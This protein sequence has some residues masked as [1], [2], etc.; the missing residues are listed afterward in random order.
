MGSEKFEALKTLGYRYITRNMDGE[1]HAWVYKPIRSMTVLAGN[2][3]RI[4]E[5]YKD[6]NINDVE[7]EA[8]ED[9]EYRDGCNVY[10]CWF[11]RSD[12]DNGDR[13]TAIPLNPNEKE[14]DKVTWENSPYE[15]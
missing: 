5:K 1:L 3:D 9:Y 12:K 7:D 4:R 15:I 11:T 8:N 10:F 14:F 6:A 13:Y 2:E